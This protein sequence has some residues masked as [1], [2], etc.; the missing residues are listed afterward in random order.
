MSIRSHGDGTAEDLW[1]LIFHGIGT[2]ATH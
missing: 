1:D 2:D